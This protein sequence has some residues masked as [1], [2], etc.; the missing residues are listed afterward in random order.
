MLGSLPMAFSAA[1]V[2][3]RV[4]ATR[5]ANL[6]TDRLQETQANVHFEAQFPRGSRIALSCPWTGEAP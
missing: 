4:E 2:I 5:I 3:V 6:V 1:K